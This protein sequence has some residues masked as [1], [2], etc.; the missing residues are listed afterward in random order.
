MSKQTYLFEGIWVKTYLEPYIEV[1]L[2][3]EMSANSILGHFVR[4]VVA[5]MK[6][7]DSVTV[8]CDT[9]TLM[10]VHSLPDDVKYNLISE[11]RSSVGQ[12]LDIIKDPNCI[13]TLSDGA[14]VYRSL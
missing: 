13:V 3:E 11:I 12:Y 6:G 7:I 8:K 10:Y 2:S 4:I 1:F 14:I 5:E 9:E